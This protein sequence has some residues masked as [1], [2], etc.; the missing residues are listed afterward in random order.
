MV[1]NFLNVATAAL[2]LMCT[3]VV[4][5]AVPSRI[6]HQGRLFDVSGDPI[7][8]VHT[9]RFALYGDSVGG[10]PLWTE[11]HSMTLQNGYYAITLGAVTPFP[12]AAL[13]GST[14]YLGISVDDD[15]EMTPREPVDSVPYAMVSA[16]AVGDITPK[17]VAVGGIRVI[18][19]DGSWVGPTHGLQG[20]A[21]TPGPQGPKGDTGA[22]G[23]A[24]PRELLARLELS[25]PWDQP[26]LRAPLDRRVPLDWW[27]PRE[28]LAT[29]DRQGPSDLRDQGGATG[30][31]GSIGPLGPTGATGATGPAGAIGPVGPRG[32]TGATG[33]AGATGPVG[34][35]GATGA[36]GAT[37]P[38]GPRGQDGRGVSVHYVEQSA[39]ITVGGA[40]QDIPGLQISFSVAQSA[41]L[42]LTANGVVAKAGGDDTAIACAVRFV[43]DASPLP[44]SNN[45]GDMRVEPKNL[46]FVAGGPAP[47]FVI[48]NASVGPGSHTARLQLTRNDFVTPGDCRIN[49]SSDTRARMKL[50]VR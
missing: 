21:G 22:T 48:K 9:M 35:R 45:N 7:T 16:N 34:P 30:A 46:A 19:E 18:A 6:N 41:T 37:G 38:S 3:N 32:A 14:R 8:G 36:T 26:E 13:D 5:Q 15:P 43:V 12:P 27:A 50:E 47:F 1:R 10:T 31:T 33:P 25:A 2:L 49:N 28:L 4:A 24:G 39:D 11:V 20:P 40:W 44:G 29:P 17:S 42:D 23:A